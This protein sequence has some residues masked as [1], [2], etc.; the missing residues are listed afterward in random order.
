MNDLLQLKRDLSGRYEHSV[1]NRR[2][3]RIMNKTVLQLT[4]RLE[5]KADHILRPDSMYWAALSNSIAGVVEAAQEVLEEAQSVDELPCIVRWFVNFCNSRSFD[6]DVKEITH[7]FIRIENAV[8]ASDRDMNIQEKL[9][10]FQN[11]SCLSTKSSMRRLSRML[12][13]IVEEESES[14]SDLEKSSDVQTNE[15]DETQLQTN[16]DEFASFNSKSHSDHCSADLRTP[17]VM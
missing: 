10:V 3:L 8:S 7:S 4:T 15:Q 1:L 13:N 17:Y 12:S 9:S 5:E 14:E 11:V 2:S 16:A 6:G